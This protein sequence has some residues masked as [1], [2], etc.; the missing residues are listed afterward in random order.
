MR[1]FKRRARTY[2]SDLYDVLRTH[3]EI[4]GETI[5]Y[6]LYAMTTTTTSMTFTMSLEMLRVCV[7]AELPVMLK[8]ISDWIFR[9]FY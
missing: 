5:S 1:T 3:K 9:Q 8:W 4:D 2:S 7:F 6:I